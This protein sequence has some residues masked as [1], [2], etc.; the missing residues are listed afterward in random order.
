MS[1]KIIK[2]TCILCPMG[3]EVNIIK[4][5]KTYEASGSRC[6]KGTEYA[7]KEL[8]CPERTVTSTVKTIFKDF[9]R[10]PVRT[11]KEVPLEKVFE[12][13]MSIN[14]IVIRKRLKPG[15]IIASD[16]TGKGVN[17]IATDNMNY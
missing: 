17:L 15:D 3:C 16:I 10:L 8:S 12:L 13:M 5:E 1:E 14:K 7:L 11:D 4:N 6:K 2:I 9:P